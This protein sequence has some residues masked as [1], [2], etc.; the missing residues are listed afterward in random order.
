MIMKMN[1]C[2]L[3]FLGAAALQG[4]AALPGILMIDD[5]ERRSPSSQTFASGGVL[6]IDH[7]DVAPARPPPAIASGP[8]ANPSAGETREP[9]DVNALGARTGVY[10]QAPSTAEFVK[11][12]S[13][14]RGG[15]GLRIIYHK[16]SKGGP[17]GNGGFCGYY[18]L[19]HT[20]P[21]SYLD[22][23][24]YSYLTF[25]VRGEKG[26]E[27]F[28]VGAAD[29]KWALTGDSAKSREIGRYLPAGRITTD[30]QQAVIPLSEFRVDLT[31]M[32]SIAICFEGG[33]YPAGIGR[34]TVYIDD[35]AFAREKPG[36]KP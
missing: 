32:H 9:A 12:E 15:A 16:K 14:G 18:T 20:D 23:S 25:W 26:D 11:G 29:R 21:T 36:A 6:V 5:M 22:A 3:W 28:S 27:K 1:W 19:L 35:L 30:W 2:M 34:G 7:M 4:Q 33:L 24:A 8:L 17:A 10:Q 31:Q 13:F